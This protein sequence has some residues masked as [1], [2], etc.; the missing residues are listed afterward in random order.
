LD[1]QLLLSFPVIFNG[2]APFRLQERLVVFS[3]I[4]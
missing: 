4:C 1:Q 2:A 3:P